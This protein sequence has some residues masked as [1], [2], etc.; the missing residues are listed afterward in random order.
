MPFVSIPGMPGRLYVPEERAECLKKFPCG[1]CFSCEHCADDRC[2]VCRED[3]DIK[4]IC[5]EEGQDF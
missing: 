4:E 3:R 1:D 5:P 2:R